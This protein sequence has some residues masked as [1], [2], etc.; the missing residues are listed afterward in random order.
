MA[1]SPK[2]IS[3]AIEQNA[4]GPKNVQSGSESVEQ[5]P[6]QDQIAADNHQAGNQ[7]GK[8]PHFGLRFSKV[9]PKYP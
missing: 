8:H 2:D 6:I 3:E 1:D 4:L 7:A 5:H 9:V